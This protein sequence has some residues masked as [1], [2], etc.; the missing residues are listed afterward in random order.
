MYYPPLFCNVTILL[1]EVHVHC[2]T[3]SLQRLILLESSITPVMSMFNVPIKQIGRS[4]SHLFW[5]R[6]WLQKRHTDCMCCC[7]LYFLP[8][9]NIIWKG[10]ETNI[11]VRLNKFGLTD[12]ESC[13]FCKQVPKTLEHLFI[14]CTQVQKF[15]TDLF[16]W[17]QQFPREVININLRVRLEDRW[18]TYFRISGQWL[19]FGFH[20]TLISTMHHVLSDYAS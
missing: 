19:K 3:P 14:T 9:I 17:H 8:I 15:W 10:V 2:T 6:P 1:V 12:N 16:G 13:S 11:N 7:N 4:E 20:K 5:R 18:S